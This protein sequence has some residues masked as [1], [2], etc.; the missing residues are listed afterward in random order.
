MGLISNAVQTLFGQ[1][2]NLVKDTAEVFTE[3]REAAATRAAHLRQVAMD[4]YGAEF[5]APSQ[6]RF[7][8]VMDGVNRLPRPALALGTLA[9]FIAAMVDPLWFAAR[10]QGLALVPEPLWWLLGAI[11]SFYFG[12]RHQIKSQQFQRS[13]V[14]TSNRAPQVAAHISA[15]D[16]IRADSIGAADTRT[17]AKLSLG[18]DTPM[19]NPALTDWKTSTAQP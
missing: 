8:R 15:L 4:Q 2:R 17:D 3:N 12:A 5:A 13:I 10:M 19:D 1:G 14:R 7:D 18:V 16:Q 6:S 11:V 9:L